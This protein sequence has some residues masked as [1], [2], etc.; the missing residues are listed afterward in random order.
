MVLVFNDKR[1]GLIEW[2]Q[3]RDF[4]RSSNISFGNPDFVK[5]AESFGCRGVCVKSTG[6]LLPALQQAKGSNVPVITDCPVDY[7]ENIRLTDRLGQL[8][9]PL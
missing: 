1:Y 5:F 9:C 6:E 7:Q 4:G 2:K 8:V 3:M